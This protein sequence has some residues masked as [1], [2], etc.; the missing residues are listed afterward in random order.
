MWNEAQLS[1]LC[2]DLGWGVE[3]NFDTDCENWYIPTF[4]D[5]WEWNPSSVIMWQLVFMRGGTVD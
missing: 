1:G 2:A 4:G 5:S 3:H